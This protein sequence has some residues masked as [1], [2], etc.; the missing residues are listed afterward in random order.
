VNQKHAHREIVEQVF[1]HVGLYLLSG[2]SLG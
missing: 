2:A 1:E